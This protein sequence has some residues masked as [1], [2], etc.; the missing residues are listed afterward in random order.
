[1]SPARRASIST[2]ALLVGTDNPGSPNLQAG[3][4]KLP[5]Y[6][7]FGGGAGVG[8]KFNRFDLSLKGDAERTRLSRLQAHRRFQR[9]Q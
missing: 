1:M 6:T 7:T 8:Q 3:L 9:K 4:A 2:A 5:I